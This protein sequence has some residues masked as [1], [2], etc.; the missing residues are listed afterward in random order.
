[1]R[2]DDKILKAQMMSAAEEVIGKL[3]AGAK[4]KKELS[5]GDIERLV[6]SAGQDVMKELTGTLA[7]AEAQGKEDRTC[8]KCRRTMR[9]KGRKKREVITETGEVS[10]KR[11]YY[12]CPRC[13]KGVFPPRPTVE[14]EQDGI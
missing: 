6:R 3:L 14:T 12:Y 11:R 9:Y 7:N 5:L 13:E 2:A 8:P 10:L 4:E 1:M